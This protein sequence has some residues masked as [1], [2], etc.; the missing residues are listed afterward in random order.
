MPVTR[1][2]MTLTTSQVKKFSET[3]KIQLNSSFL[4]PI[5][6]KACLSLESG[7]STVYFILFNNA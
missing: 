4:I 7:L 2:F 6:P 5:L 1:N 3:L